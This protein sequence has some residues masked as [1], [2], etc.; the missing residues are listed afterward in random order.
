VTTLLALVVAFIT[1]YAVH[2]THGPYW[3]ALGFGLTVLNITLT[4]DRIV[5]A[6]RRNH[7]PTG[8]AK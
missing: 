2:V 6:I 4:G 5:A 1:G 8:G 3:A 7:T